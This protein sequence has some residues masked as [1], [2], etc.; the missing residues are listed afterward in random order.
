MR[1]NLNKMLLFSEVFSIM[2]NKIRSPNIAWI[3]RDKL[4]KLSTVEKNS[5]NVFSSY[6]VMYTMHYYVKDRPRLLLLKF[7]APISSDAP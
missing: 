4:L 2:T 6:I 5:H 1:W 7:E 3:D